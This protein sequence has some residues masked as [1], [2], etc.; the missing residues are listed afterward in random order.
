MCDVLTQ[1]TCHSARDGGGCWIRAD[2]NIHR[3]DSF[4]QARKKLC[5]SAAPVS[6]TMLAPNRGLA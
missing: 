5:G 6:T 4:E 1:E 3:H 2:Y